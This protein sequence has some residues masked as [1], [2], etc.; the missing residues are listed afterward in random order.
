MCFRVN[1]K[2]PNASQCVK[3]RVLNK[4]IDSILSIDT[5]EQQCVVI[6]CMVQSPRLED[7]MNTIGVDQSL[8]NRSYFEHKCLN[9]IKMIYQH[10]GNSDNQQNLK[11]IIEYAL[12]SNP[13]VFTDNS[14]NAHISE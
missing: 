4:A 6:K 11:D 3:S 7:H 9:N 1:R 12:L 13:E 8:C 14:P 10:A 2:A 5:F